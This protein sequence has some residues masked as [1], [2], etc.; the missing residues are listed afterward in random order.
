MGHPTVFSHLSETEA[1]ELEN[2]LTALRVESDELN[3]SAALVWL[4]KDRIK[5]DA[6]LHGI[7]LK[8]PDRVDEIA[9]NSFLSLFPDILRHRAVRHLLPES[10]DASK[11]LDA[12]ANH[13]PRGWRPVPAI[14]L[15]AE[16]AR[17]MY[18]GSF[19]T[20]PRESAAA[21][22]DR[23][24]VA[25]LAQAN[26]LFHSLFGERYSSLFCL[27]SPDPWCPWFRGLFN[28]TW[29]VY[30]GHSRTLWMLT[31]TDMD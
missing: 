12:G 20:D 19:G 16:W 10:F 22:R 24:A 21:V 14:G 4:R 30:A 8:A 26:D 7:V 29:V 25:A 31:L 1:G 2:D 11:P 3:Q 13:P 5:G 18:D 6:Q 27:S 9:R 28:T 17:A 23:R 15:A